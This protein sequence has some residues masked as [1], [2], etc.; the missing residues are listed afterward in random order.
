[1]AIAVAK[2]RPPSTS[3]RPDDAKS[4]RQPENAKLSDVLEHLNET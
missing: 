3:Y 2:Q 1:V 4:H